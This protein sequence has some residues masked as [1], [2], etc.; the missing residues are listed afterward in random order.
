MAPRF[1]QEI[2]TRFLRRLTQV[3]LLPKNT[4]AGH[5]CNPGRYTVAR[6]PQRR[7]FMADICSLRWR[8]P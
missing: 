7:F 5:T 6:R 3:Y 2:E 1:R 8:G 4:L